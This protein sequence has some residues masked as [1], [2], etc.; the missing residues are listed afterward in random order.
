MSV[1]LSLEGKNYKQCQNK[2]TPLDKLQRFIATENNFSP[3]NGLAYIRSEKIVLVL[4][5]TIS[6]KHFPFFVTDVP[7]TLEYLSLA[8]LSSLVYI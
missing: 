7:N 6:D 5:E 2:Q 4:H 8:S 1:Y 3:E